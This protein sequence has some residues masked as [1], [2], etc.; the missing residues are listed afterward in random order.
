MSRRANTTAARSPHRYS[1]SSCRR[2]CGCSKCRTMRRS[3]RSPRPR[4]RGRV[5]ER[6]MDVLQR[7][8]LK[9]VVIERL[10]ADSRRC[11][12]GS[13]FF[14]YPGEKADGRAFIG[15]AL[16][17]GASAVLWESENFA[18]PHA[19]RAPNVAVPGLKQQ[20]S[21]L[22]SRFHGEPSHALWMC[23][24]TGTNGKTS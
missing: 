21:L 20:A 6:A 8:A 15:D 4:R 3:S 1:P 14:A 5:L 13:A 2:R 24:V 18:W 22:A 19:W 11:A 17:R 9:G 16:A 12:P 7:L 23:G 10:S